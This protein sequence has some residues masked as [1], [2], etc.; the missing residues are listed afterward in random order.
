MLLV[1][2][3]RG[4]PQTC[5]TGSTL[6]PPQLTHARRNVRL[7]LG[8]LQQR[9]LPLLGQFPPLHLAHLLHLP[10][11]T[12]QSFPTLLLFLLDLGF[13]PFS[14]PPNHRPFPTNIPPHTV[15]FAE[16]VAPGFLHATGFGGACSSRAHV[17]GSGSFPSSGGGVGDRAGARGGEGGSSEGSADG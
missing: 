13:F 5:S 3:R 6:M 2:A 17:L 8:P 4:F 7:C 12:P 11:P 10:P 15:D 9:H 1:S 16:R 14:S